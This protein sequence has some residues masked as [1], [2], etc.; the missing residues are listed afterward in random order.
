MQSN[1]GD[2]PQEQQVRG[3]LLQNRDQYCE[4]IVI[5][6]STIIVLWS[7]TIVLDYSTIGDQ[8]TERI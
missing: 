2:T 5:Y 1:P 8:C 3:H 7:S 4:T 6:Y